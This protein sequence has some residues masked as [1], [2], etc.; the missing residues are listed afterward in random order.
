MDIFEALRKD[1]DTQRTLID[2]VCKT[3][4]DSEGRNELFA[5]LRDA[6]E[7]HAKAEERFFYV[8]LMQ[9]DAT[10]ER[11][12]HSVA[13]HQEVD[14]LIAELADTDFSSPGWLATARKLQERLIHHLDEEEHEVFQLAGKKLSEKEKQA[15]AT[16]YRQTMDADSPEP[17]PLQLQL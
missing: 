6:V 15:L 13:E 5:Q 7:R 16:R 3:S 4:G 11:A 8:P 12:R 2:L 1:H 14:E 10:Q 9:H 17:E